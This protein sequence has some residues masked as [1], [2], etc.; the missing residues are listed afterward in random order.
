MQVLAATDR[1]AGRLA[2]AAATLGQLALVCLGVH[3]AAD[4]LD[5]DIA[6]LLTSIESLLDIH[7]TGPASA[8]AEAMGLGYD[9]LLLWDGLPIGPM[10]AYF[11]LGIELGAIAVFTAGFLLTQRKPRI[12][13]AAWRG[14]LSVHA[15]VLPLSLAGVMLAGGWSM[16]M[17]VEDLLPVTVVS[18]W[19]GA[20]VGIAALIRFGWPAWA[21]SIAAL[22]PADRWTRGLGP[23][24]FIAPM[25]LL[26]W[27]HGIPIWGWLP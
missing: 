27:M 1:A 23:A 18:P 6:R 21:R 5:D 26:A 20:A 25:G 24:F 7:L 10:S 12:S 14:V 8:T 9:A 11:A 2:H 13:F 16:A 4:R 22:E 3:L 17:A 19:A 15:V